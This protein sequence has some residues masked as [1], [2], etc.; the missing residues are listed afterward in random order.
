MIRSRWWW[1]WLNRTN[2][3]VCETNMDRKPIGSE[4]RVTKLGQ[5]MS[6]R[7]L[8]QGVITHRRPYRQTHESNGYPPWNWRCSL[9]G[10]YLGAGNDPA[11]YWVHELSFHGSCVHRSL[12]LPEVPEMTNGKVYGQKFTEKC[13]IA[14]EPVEAS[15]RGK[16]V[17]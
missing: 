8:H 2:A 3:N 13:C 14:C 7:C 10:A 16:R 5:N 4:N 1:Q 17:V 12:G 15:V 11:R 6:T 9:S